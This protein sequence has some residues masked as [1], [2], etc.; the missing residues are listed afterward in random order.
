MSKHPFN[1][2]A[3]TR[4][5]YWITEREALRKRKESGA[6]QP[7][8]KDPILSK[9][10]FCNVRRNDDRVT[11]WVHDNWLQ[12]FSGDPDLWFMMVVARLVNWPETLYELSAAVLEGKKNDRVTWR[13]DV[14]VREMHAR[15]ANG[16]K[17][18]SGAYIVSTNGHKMDK[19]EY[20]AAKVLTPLWERQ[21]AIRPEPEDTLAEFHYRLCQYDGMGSFMAAQVVADIKYDQQGPLW[22]CADWQTWAAP[23]PGSI[24]GLVRLLSGDCDP[25]TIR[26]SEKAWVVSFNKLWPL[27]QGWLKDGVLTGQD[28]QNCLCEYDKYER[29]RLGQGTPRALYK[30]H[31][32]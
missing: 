21:A 8:T 12:P 29:V 3:L 18:F 14:F 7:W 25:E 22:Q 17:V 32:A 1:K 24:R 31:G 10:R 4:L 30:S 13:P 19:A 23:G 28:L 5:K 15:K 16:H 9:F 11:R 20:L 27:A 6:P 2:E 26:L